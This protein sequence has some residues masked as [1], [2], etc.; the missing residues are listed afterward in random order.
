[1][2]LCYF[3]VLYTLVLKEAGIHKLLISNLKHYKLYFNYFN[4]YY[5]FVKVLAN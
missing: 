1:M 3:Y 4:Q 5:N 2:I